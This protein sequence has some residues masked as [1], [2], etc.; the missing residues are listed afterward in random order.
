MLTFPWNHK[1][2]IVCLTKLI[3]HNHGHSDEGGFTE[4]SHEYEYKR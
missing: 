2:I 4:W 3:E 1:L